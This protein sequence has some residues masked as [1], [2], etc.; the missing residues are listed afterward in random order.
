M[1]DFVI[2]TLVRRLIAKH[3]LPWTI[4]HDWTVEVHD[5]KKQCVMQLQTNAD[6]TELIE[7]AAALVI[8]DKKAEEECDQYMR[9]LGLEE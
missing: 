5:A 1:N 7:Y 4:E 9:E 3:P 8:A 6:A 2:K